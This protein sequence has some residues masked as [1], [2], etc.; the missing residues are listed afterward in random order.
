MTIT[1][2]NITD[3]ML[4]MKDDRQ[5]QLL[6]RFFKTGMGEYGE[7]D[8]F[9]GLKVQQTRIVARE[10]KHHVPLTEVERLC[11]LLILTDEM[12]AALPT[13]KSTGDA[14]RR[15][16]ITHFY[17]Q[18]AERVNNWDLV[19]LSCPAI[20]GTWLLFPCPDGT[21]PD[22]SVLDKL[23]CSALLWKQRI[24]IVST[25]ALIR[26]GQFGNT[27]RIAAVLLHHQHDLIHK[28]VGWMLREVGKR[29]VTVLRCFLEQHGTDMPRTMLRYAIERMDSTERM[30]WM[31]QTRTVKKR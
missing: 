22:R 28:A 25:L 14:V 20:L 29:D 5:Q 11:A 26:K 21:L 13:A 6:Q 2:E 30:W 31:Q 4:A 7:G 8:R 15:L 3:T 16:Q 18:H 24:A 17:L 19:D 10:A 27:L 12:K 9:L 1:A 23:A